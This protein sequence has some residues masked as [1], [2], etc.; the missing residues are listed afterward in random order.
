MRG[1]PIPTVE[2]ATSV[3]PPDRRVP[4]VRPR[5]LSPKDLAAIPIDWAVPPRL[6]VADRC[7]WR[8]ASTPVAD[9]GGTS[10]A[11]I[12]LI[13]REGDCGPSPLDDA[14]SK[15]I[16]AAV[17]ASPVWAHRFVTLYYRRGLSAPEIAKALAMK[18]REYVYAER[19]Q[20]LFYYLGRLHEIGFTLASQA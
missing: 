19:D 16:D 17:R 11:S 3:D 1:A 6:R 4:E 12:V 13:R 14:E 15:I 9:D 18:R 2:R 20:V 8:W 10:I 5:K 7:F